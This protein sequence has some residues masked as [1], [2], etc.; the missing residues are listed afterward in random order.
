MTEL[1]DDMVF[2]VWDQRGTGTSYAALDPTDTLTLRQAVSDT[3]ELAEYLGERFGQQRIYLFGN[4][5][6]ST[7]GV[8]AAQ[9]RPD[10]FRA[11][12][13]AG[14]MVSQRATDQMLYQDVLDL[15]ART[16]DAALAER[17]RAYGPP[18]YRDITAYA[19]VLGYYDALD[20]YEKTAYFTT[21]GPS[22]ID[23]TGASEYGPLDKVNKEKALADTLL[24]AV[25]AAAGRRPAHAGALARRPGLPGGGHA[26]A[27]QP[28]RAGPRVVR[29]PAG[30]GQAVGH[31]RGLGPCASV[32]TV[33]P[34]PRAHAG[35]HHCEGHPL[36]RGH[37]L[38]GH[39]RPPAGGRLTPAV[40]RYPP[41]PR[42]RG[43]T[44]CA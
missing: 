1:A 13:G 12:I 32:R 21:Q 19:V 28:K 33:P 42:E 16:G 41:L 34:V 29:R 5:W 26:R 15:A 31:V 8:L 18:P 22:G 2:A 38:S 3:I 27:A 4:S 17:M 14:Q 25:P 10:L 24:G 37:P 43:F 39:V 35:H 44:P 23:G 40:T 9:Q 20:S 7:L 30:A 36:M 11:Y 6:G